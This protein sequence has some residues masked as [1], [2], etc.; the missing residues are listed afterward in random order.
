MWPFATTGGLGDVVAALPAALATLGLDL[1]VVLPRYSGIDLGTAVDRFVL[2]RLDRRLEAVIWEHEV[3]PRVRAVFVECA[4]LYDRDGLY[5]VGNEDYADNPR[6]FAGLTVAALEYAAR[7][8]A[9]PDVIHTHDWQ[10]G[11]APV[12][13]KTRP[14]AWPVLASVPTVFTIHNLAY[15][16]LCSSDW[17]GRLGLDEGLLSVDGLEYWGRASFLKGGINFCDAVTTVSPSYALEIQTPAYGFGFDGILSA[18]SADLVG[19]LNGVDAARWSPAHDLHLPVTYDAMTIGIGKRAAKHQLLRHME[20]PA[21]AAALKRPLVGMISRLVEQKGLDLVEALGDDLAQLGASF[22]VLGSGDARY[23]DFWTS[24]ASRYRDTVSVRIGF[25]EPLA[26]LIEAGADMFLMP[27]RFEPCGLNQMYSLRYGTVPIVR[28]TGGLRD[29]VVDYRPGRPG[30][31]GFTFADYTPEALREALTRALDAYGKPRT[32]K[33][34][35]LRGMSQN[36]SWD[37]SAREYVKL[38]DR[39]LGRRPAAG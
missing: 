7:Q 22:V 30:G 26:H 35:Q 25:D 38:Y 33:T 17:L 6:R 2:P 29:T 14:D 27:S 36:F 39:V 18:R 19:V 10:T 23:Q 9:P 13:L 24:L 20:L 16:G 11:F 37:K 21:D 5:G 12:Y 4:A 28:A 34:L 3:G 31:T 15:Q 32:W 8:A 1:T